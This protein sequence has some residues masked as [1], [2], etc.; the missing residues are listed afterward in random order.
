[1]NGYIALIKAEGYRVFMRKPSDSYCYFTDGTRIGYAQWSDYRTCV[2]SVHKPSRQN[3][4]G[5]RI[6]DAINSE[7]LSD[8]INCYIPSLASGSVEKF[9]DWSA[10]HNA[11]SW[12]RQLVEV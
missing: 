3:G 7:S 2:S 8:A 12:N 10:F 5:F 6:A 4:T 1:M 9:K 11:D